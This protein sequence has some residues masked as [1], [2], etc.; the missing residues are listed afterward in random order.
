MSPTINGDATDETR[1]R[2]GKLG[3]MLGDDEAG[4]VGSMV[5]YCLDVRQEEWR[6]FYINERK[7]AEYDAALKAAEEGNRI[8]EDEDGEEVVDGME[9]DPFVDM[10]SE[11][12]KEET[13]EDI[14]GL[15]EE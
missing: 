5:L 8:I 10:D 14:E 15:G 4:I 1:N 11:E 2:I 12:I 7:E 6:E 13:F 3:E 9:K